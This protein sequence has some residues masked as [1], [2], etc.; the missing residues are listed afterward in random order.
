M[1]TDVLGAKLRGKDALGSDRDAVLAAGGPQGAGPHLRER[2]RTPDSQRQHAALRQRQGPVD[3]IT[4]VSSLA[5]PPAVYKRDT[6][7]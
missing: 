1:L 5:I 7:L 2:P 6:A 3:V 4:L